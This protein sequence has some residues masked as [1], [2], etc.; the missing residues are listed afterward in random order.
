M[1]FLFAAIGAVL[2]SLVDVG[3]KVV[4][5]KSNTY[6]SIWGIFLC[7]LPLLFIFLIIDGI[8]SVDWVFWPLAVFMAIL[9]CFGEI[10]FYKAIKLSDLSDCIPFMAFTPAFL[11]FTSWI[12]LG[13]LPNFWGLMAIIIII[14]GAWIHGL[15]HERKGILAPLKSM[16]RNK[17]AMY[18]LIIDLIWSITGPIAKIAIDN[19]SEVFFTTI[20]IFILALIF[21]GIVLI[22]FR[23]KIK[24]QFAKHLWKFFLIGNLWGLAAL[25]EMMAMALILVPYVGAIKQ[26][27]SL[28]STI[29]G[30]VLFKEKHLKPRLIGAA[31][32]VI[33]AV[34]IVVLG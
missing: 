4:L 6:I 33:G 27:R 11:I 22:R 19:S 12:I 32:M 3:R 7:S 15:D 28:Y 2:F 29:L 9:I 31:V 10:Y 14:F 20:F 18:I 26:T 23:D 21:T 24:E 1:G 25:L 13:Q 17:G 30:K 34:I 16:F 8:P 5:K